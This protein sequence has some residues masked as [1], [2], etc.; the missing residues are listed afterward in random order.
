[1][2]FLQICWGVNFLNWM[3]IIH[4]DLHSS[5]IFIDDW[6]PNNIIV[7]IGDFSKSRHIPENKR[8][9]CKNDE[10]T[11]ICRPPELIEGLLSGRAAD[12]W[13]IGNLLYY[14]MSF[15]YPYGDPSN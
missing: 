15:E 11:L 2:I 10:I 5:N 4:F 6:D 3:N 12:T 7:K 1:M 9:D 14:M 13:A 8:S